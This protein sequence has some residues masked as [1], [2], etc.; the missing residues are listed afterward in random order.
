MGKNIM[1]VFG[2]Q[3]GKSAGTADS[4]VS[5]DAESAATLGVTQRSVMTLGKT[6]SFKGELSAD[7][8]LI[9]MGRVEG[10]ISHTASVTVG[11]GGVVIGDIHA[12]FITIKGS[13]EG[14]LEATESIVI[15]P[16]ATVTGDLAAPRVGI[17]EGA[18][19]V[20]AVKMTAAPVPDVSAATPPTFELPA[21]NTIAGDKAVEKILGG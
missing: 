3:P 20:G 13:V 16:T 2:S 9:L 21:G 17:V 15:A 7:E 19:F 6:L 11:Q 5:S 4:T 10:M 8:D 12:R 14:D 18:K 1:S